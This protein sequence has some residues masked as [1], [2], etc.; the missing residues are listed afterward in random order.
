MDDPMSIMDRVLGMEDSNPKYLVSKIETT[1]IGTEIN[2]TFL[3]TF[4]F[5]VVFC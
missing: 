1:K 3:R 5:L 4:L 2:Q